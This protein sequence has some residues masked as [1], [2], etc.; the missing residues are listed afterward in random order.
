MKEIT[1]FKVQ[2]YFYFLNGWKWEGF[3]KT[4]PS[5]KSERWHTY[6]VTSLQ[7]FQ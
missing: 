3:T 5:Q 1:S 4:S 7:G 2:F 6:T